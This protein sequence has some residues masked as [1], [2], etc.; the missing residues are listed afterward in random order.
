MKDG[1]A[2][3]VPISKCFELLKDQS[4]NHNHTSNE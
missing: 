3:K 1:H 2:F 4:A